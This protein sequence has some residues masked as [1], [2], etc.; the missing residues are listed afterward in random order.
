MEAAMRVFEMTKQFP[1]EERPSMVVQM[2]RSSRAVC[3][4]I[5]EAWRRRRSQAQFVGKLGDAEGEAEETRVWIDFAA[6]YGY[7]RHD[8]A[9]DLSERYDKILAQL[10]K[11]ISDPERWAIRPRDA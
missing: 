8:E 2:R 5:G 3:A 11:M 4:G 9:D 7:L 6:R 10:V 1:A